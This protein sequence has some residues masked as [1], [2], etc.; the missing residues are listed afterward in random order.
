MALFSLAEEKRQGLEMSGR[1][2]TVGITNG[3]LRRT[4]LRGRE[5]VLAG[6][7][8]G[9]DWRR[10][11]RVSPAVRLAAAALADG[12]LVAREKRGGVAMHTPLFL[13]HTPPVTSY[14]SHM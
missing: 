13:A 2:A 12:I 10:W 3:S 8:S 14:T 6:D 4:G 9:G 1:P 7:A 11:R 5:R